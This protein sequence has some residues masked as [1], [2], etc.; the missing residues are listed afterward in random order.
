MSESQMGNQHR[1]GKKDSDE[2]KNKKSKAQK[3]ISKNKG[4]VHSPEHNLKISKTK[5]E[6]NFKFSDEQK[7]KMSN[8]KLGWNITWGDKIGESKRGIPIKGKLIIQ[9]DLLNN[10]IREWDSMSKAARYIGKDS[11]GIK[12]CCDNKQNTCGGFK[13]KYKN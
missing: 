1:K 3:G 12:H 10:I 7:F 5:K 6:Q 4:Y 8:T 11:S 2:T 13:W 9:F